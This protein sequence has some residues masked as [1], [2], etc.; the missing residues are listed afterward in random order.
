ML[1]VL[2]SDERTGQYERLEQDVGGRGPDSAA[3]CCRV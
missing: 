1:R 2:G 3:S